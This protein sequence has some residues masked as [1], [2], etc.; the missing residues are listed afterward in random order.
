MEKKTP[1]GGRARS[2]Q[3]DPQEYGCS[4]QADMQPHPQPPTE[5]R[6]I[7]SVHAV[8]GGMDLTFATAPGGKFAGEC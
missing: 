1:H 2:S 4:R 6:P 5:S 7:A 8:P 3:N